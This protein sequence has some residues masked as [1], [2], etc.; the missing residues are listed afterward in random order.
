MYPKRKFL[1]I[2]NYLNQRMLLLPGFTTVKKDISGLMPL[3][4]FKLRVC[5][6]N[7]HGLIFDLALS[8]VPFTSASMFVLIRHEAAS[9]AW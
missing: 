8:F 6:M 3:S 2:V 7:K 1:S 5:H 9:R 4:F